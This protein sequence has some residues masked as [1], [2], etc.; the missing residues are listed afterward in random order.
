MSVDLTG[1]VPSSNHVKTTIVW[2]V[3]TGT[4]LSQSVRPSWCLVNRISYRLSNLPSASRSHATL[5]CVEKCAK[6]EG[7]A[8]ACAKSDASDERS[9]TRAGARERAERATPRPRPP[10]RPRG[11]A[12]RRDSPTG[13]ARARATENTPKSLAARKYHVYP[14][15]CSSNNV[16]VPRLSTHP[17][18][19][20]G[21]FQHNAMC[22]R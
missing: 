21:N 20:H 3:S 4:V 17:H 14:L 18:G 6:T 12:P 9:V 11:A 22:I 2:F 1:H 5:C 16:A 13:R 15:Q 19:Q 10:P 7:E 8:C